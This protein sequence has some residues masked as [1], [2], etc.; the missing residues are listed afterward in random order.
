MNKTSVVVAMVGTVAVALSGCAYLNGDARRLG[1]DQKSVS[2]SNTLLTW[3]DTEYAFGEGNLPFCFTCKPSNTPYA[4]AV[5]VSTNGVFKMRLSYYCFD[6]T[7]KEKDTVIAVSNGVATVSGA[8]RCEYWQRETQCW[9]KCG[10]MIPQCERLC[11]FLDTKRG[12]WR[13][14]A[15]SADCEHSYRLNGKFMR[16]KLQQ[17][18]SFVIEECRGVEF[19]HGSNWYEW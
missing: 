15:S 6:A 14:S 19:L 8:E 12:M 1:K 7:S 10:T 16:E 2:V 4:F 9:T 13:V 3:T 5:M 17:P 18:R 11:L